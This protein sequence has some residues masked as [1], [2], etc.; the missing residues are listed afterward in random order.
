MF[1]GWPCLVWRQTSL[2]FLQP[3]VPRSFARPGGL[4]AVFPISAV[5]RIGGLQSTA[6]RLQ[7]QTDGG[8][9][10]QVLLQKLV[11]RFEVGAMELP[12]EGD[13]QG[14]HWWYDWWKANGHAQLK[15][16]IVADG[17]HRNPGRPKPGSPQFTTRTQGVFARLAHVRAG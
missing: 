3:W 1:F 10:H 7:I 14:E 8:Q 5:W 2:T 11:I 4:G 16:G 12:L 13:F 6:K 15:V 17:L 9:L